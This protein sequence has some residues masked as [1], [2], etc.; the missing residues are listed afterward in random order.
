MSEKNI[1]FYVKAIEK[2]ELDYENH[3]YSE[4]I[5]ALFMM[6]SV[7][8]SDVILQQKNKRESCDKKKKLETLFSIKLKKLKKLLEN[9]EINEET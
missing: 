8:L 9:Y 6:L 4:N 3:N 2:F 7:V 5:F 1:R